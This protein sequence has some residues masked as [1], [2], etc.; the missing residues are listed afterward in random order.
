MQTNPLSTCRP[1]SS[2]LTQPSK[3]CAAGAAAGEARQVI[4]VPGAPPVSIRWGS[5]PSASQGAAAQ[6]CLQLNLQRRPSIQTWHV[7][8]SHAETDRQM[9]LLCT[10]LSRFRLYSFVPSAVAHHAGCWA[11]NCGAPVKFA[12]KAS[13]KVWVWLYAASLCLQHLRHHKHT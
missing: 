5:R 4:Q 9:R 13:F 6:V 10:T 8:L 11:M 12:F 3:V 7:S 1:S 2:L